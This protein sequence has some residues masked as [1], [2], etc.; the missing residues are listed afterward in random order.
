[1]ENKTKE[2]GNCYLVIDNYR[3]EQK[4]KRERRELDRCC[5]ARTAKSVRRNT[6]K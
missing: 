6:L 1:M 4:V 3:Q 5:K 2:Y